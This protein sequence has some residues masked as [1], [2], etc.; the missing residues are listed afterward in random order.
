MTWIGRMRL[1]RTLRR[2]MSAQAKADRT[3]ED[4]RALIPQ[5]RAF[6]EQLRTQAKDADAEH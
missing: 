3:I 4:I 2:T 5:I 1:R 6:T